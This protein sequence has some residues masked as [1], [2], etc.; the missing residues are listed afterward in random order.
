MQR[1]MFLVMLLPKGL[2]KCADKLANGPC[3]V[4]CAATMNPAGRKC[5]SELAVCISVS[6]ENL[7][8]VHAEFAEQRRFLFLKEWFKHFQAD[9]E[10]R[11][12]L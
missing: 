8:L 12:T 3:P 7:L 11:P 9:V 5:C 4:A 10:V 2:L 6:P 1:P